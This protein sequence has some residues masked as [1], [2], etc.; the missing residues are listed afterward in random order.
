MKTPE[1]LQ[2]EYSKLCVQAGDLRYRIKRLEAD[3]ERIDV[4]VKRLDQLYYQSTKIP[5]EELI[6]NPQETKAP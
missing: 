6:E 4:E 2:I 5:Q 1:E 3:L